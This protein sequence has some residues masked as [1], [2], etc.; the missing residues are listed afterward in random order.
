MKVTFGLLVCVSTVVFVLVVSSGCK[1]ETEHVASGYQL[2]LSDETVQ[3]ILVPEKDSVSAGEPFTFIFGILNGTQNPVEFDGRMH[4]PGNLDVY[5]ILPNSRKV[6]ATT[7]AMR[8]TRPTE[9][10]MVTLQSGRLYGTTVAVHPDDSATAKELANPTPGTYVFW[11]QYYGRKPTEEQPL[12]LTSNQVT[13]RVDAS[14]MPD[15]ARK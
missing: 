8:L 12:S 5:A 10:D 6:R 9:D 1:R 14:T 15:K 13:V 7:L 11:V 2:H 3:A 4:R